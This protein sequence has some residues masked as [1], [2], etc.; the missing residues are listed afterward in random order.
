MEIR[1]VYDDP[2]PDDGLRVLVD[3]LWP[4]GRSKADAH[5]DEWLKDVAPSSGLRRWFG[6]DPSRF[7]EFARRYRVEL[8]HNP[9]VAELVSLVRDH[10]VVT[11]L[12]GARDERHNQAVVLRDVLGDQLRD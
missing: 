4:R 5:V 10:E 12:Y 1:R 11:L 3:R 9:A 6:H 8:D 2:G 7:D